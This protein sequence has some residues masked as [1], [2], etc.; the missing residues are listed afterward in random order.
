MCPFH[1]F[2][3][4]CSFFP[5]DFD[6]SFCFHYRETVFA[7]PLESEQYQYKYKQQTIENTICTNIT[8]HTIHY[9]TATK[10]KTKKNQQI[11]THEQSNRI[12]I[13]TQLRHLAID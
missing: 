9:I 4:C 12:P 10:I 13:H 8:R 11:N 3:V 5:F 2:H 1:R 6:L 7:A